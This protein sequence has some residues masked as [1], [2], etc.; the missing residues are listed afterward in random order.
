MNAINCLKGKINFTLFAF[1]PYSCSFKNLTSGAACPDTQLRTVF[2]CW[3][4]W[5]RTKGTWYN[6]TIKFTSKFTRISRSRG[7]EKKTKFHSC[8]KAACKSQ[9]IFV[10]DVHNFPPRGRGNPRWFPVLLW[11]VDK[12]NG[13]SDWFPEHLTRELGMTFS[14][15]VH[16]IK[17]ALAKKFSVQN[18]KTSAS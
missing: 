15:E 5:I 7:K 4:L 11:L 1:C 6:W 12:L 2:H 13:E 3:R 10:D 9:F 18:N 17:T 14:I 16:W 8:R